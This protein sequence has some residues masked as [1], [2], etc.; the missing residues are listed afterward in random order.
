MYEGM[1][2][3]TIKKDDV[4]AYLEAVV[5]EELKRIESER[6]DES[7]AVSPAE[8]RMRWMTDRAEACALRLLAQR[9]HAADLMPEDMD[10]LREQGFRPA[11][12]SLVLE[13]LFALK[14]RFWGAEPPVLSPSPEDVFGERTITEAGYRHLRSAAFEGRARALEQSDRR[15][16]IHPGADPST[17]AAQDTN[18]TQPAMSERPASPP[19]SD[20]D[21][22][23][24]ADRMS[25]KSRALRV[26]DKSFDKKAFER[27][28]RQ[29]DRVISQFIEATA[30]SKVTD[31]RQEDVA[32]YVNCL[33]RLP[34]TYNK[35][36]ADRA[37]SFEQ[38]MER[39]DELPDDLVGLSGSTE[40]R[41]LTFVGAM[42]SYARSE[43]LR[44]AEDLDL[45][46]FRTKD[47][48]LKRAQR[49][50]FTRDDIAA[51]FSHPTWRGR[52]SAARPHAL[53]DEI[54][55]DGLYWVPLIA[56][57]SGAR[58]E[59]IAGLELTDIVFDASVPHIIIR[60]NANRGLK[61]PQSER[62]LPLHSHLLELELRPYCE[63]LV[64]RGETTLFPDLRPPAPTHA[65][66]DMIHLRWSEVRKRQLGS[67]YSG[68][69]FHSFRHYVSGYLQNETTIPQL[70]VK[71]LL[72]HL[73][74]DITADR[75]R[76]PS[77]LGKLAEAVQQL[78]RVY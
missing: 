59:E 40:N 17:S 27:D 13:L 71:D 12:M 44:P 42:L 70:V 62:L 39:G 4:R 41:N 54:V 20:P 33:S 56:S 11:E 37:L 9:G 22:V 19:R 29:R 36:T 35:S 52:Q 58:R 24:I 57:Y 5:A 6:W 8:W 45:T 10:V 67:D 47:R 69:V 68:K 1:K 53:G 55:R 60:P 64:E 15:D 7:P 66:R 76:D 78:P 25:Q 28:K 30:K 38:V 21:I 48:T 43:G 14:E 74:G 18:T 32:Y 16:I 73:S 50:A 75:Y 2:A 31:L 51:I 63:G 77:H 49:P 34:K 26:K 23:S 72:G 65:F 61:N 46:W 3:Q